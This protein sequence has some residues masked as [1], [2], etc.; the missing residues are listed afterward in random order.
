MFE[1]NA[2]TDLLCILQIK[3]IIDSTTKTI[4]TSLVSCNWDFQAVSLR[5]SLSWVDHCS[6]LLLKYSH[7]CLK[8]TWKV[9]SLMGG[10][11]QSSIIY[12]FILHLACSCSTFATPPF[13]LNLSFTWNQSCTTA[14]Q[15]V[16][17]PKKKFRFAPSPWQPVQLD[18]C[19]FPFPPWSFQSTTQL[20]PFRIF[21]SEKNTSIFHGKFS[22]PKTFVF[23]PTC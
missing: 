8:S 13:F 10:Q 19:A 6:S 12:E 5:A 20:I 9:R 3:V 17:P 2:N 18:T 22:S 23:S 4:Q 14:I 7:N 11:V 16:L 15:R 21:C 1:G